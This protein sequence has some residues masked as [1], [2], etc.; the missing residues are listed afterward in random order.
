MEFAVNDDF[1]KWI[2]K[3]GRF[4]ESIAGKVLEAFVDAFHHCHSHGVFHRDVK[5]EKL[6]LW[7]NG[8]VEVTSFRLSVMMNQYESLLR[9]NCERL[10]YCAVD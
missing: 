2:S 1:V 4:A 8:L 9:T 3:H 6:F 7:I 10:Y 5:A